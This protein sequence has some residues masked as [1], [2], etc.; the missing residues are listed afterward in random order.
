MQYRGPR[1]AVTPASRDGSSFQY[2][3]DPRDNQRQ[4]RTVTS[5]GAMHKNM[6]IQ[7]VRLSAGP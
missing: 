1:L 7:P 4:K 6:N 5:S 3:H 2:T